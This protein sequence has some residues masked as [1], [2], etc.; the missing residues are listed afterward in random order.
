[1][2]NR[3]GAECK[4]KINAEGAE[5]AEFAE[6]KRKRRTGLKTRHYKCKG[7]RRNGAGWKPEFPGLGIGA[8]VGACQVLDAAA[9]EALLGE[10]FGEDDLGGNENG[11]LTGLVGDGDFD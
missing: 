7:E 5:N 11:G 6:K 8:G 10:F 1:M 2:V 9:V 3:R 4:E